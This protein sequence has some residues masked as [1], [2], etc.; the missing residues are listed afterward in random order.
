VTAQNLKSA[1]QH[2]AIYVFGSFQNMRVFDIDFQLPFT[3]IIKLNSIKSFIKR[4]AKANPVGYRNR[5]AKA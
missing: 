1:L 3:F 5:S 2:G 4:C